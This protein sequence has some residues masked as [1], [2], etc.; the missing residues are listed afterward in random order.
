MSD[1]Q[2]ISKAALRQASGWPNV[3]QAAAEQARAPAK[4]AEPE[5][6]PKRRGRPPKI[7]IEAQA[8]ANDDGDI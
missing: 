7:D 6:A 8:D 1:E 3:A 5:D 4:V 2:P